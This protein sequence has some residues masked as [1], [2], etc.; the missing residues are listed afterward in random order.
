M[1]VIQKAYFLLVFSFVKKKKKK[2][3]CHV[4]LE[5]NTEQTGQ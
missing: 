4:A 2:T 3:H 1:F 5:A